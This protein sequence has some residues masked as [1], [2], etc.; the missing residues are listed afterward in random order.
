MISVTVTQVDLK[1]LDRAN[2]DRTS[3]LNELLII[4]SY[5]NK[6]NTNIVAESV[7]GINL[8]QMIDY[9]S[10]LKVSAKGY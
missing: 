4:T 7:T 5:W 8:R 10:L 3:R 9:Q 2:I 1:S 6:F